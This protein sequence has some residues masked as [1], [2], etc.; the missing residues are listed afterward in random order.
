MKFIILS[1]LALFLGGCATTNY[2]T[3]VTDYEVVETKKPTK[4]AYKKLTSNQLKNL[5][6]IGIAS[7]YGPRWNGRRTANG[8]ILNLNELTAAHKTL[9]FN[10]IVKVTDLDTGRSIIVRI[11]DRGPYISGR[12]IDLTDYAAKKLGILQKGIARVKLEVIG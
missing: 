7:Y 6:Q 10:T 9:P 12:I 2:S 1:L 8:E 3:Q 11:N 4:K 5:K